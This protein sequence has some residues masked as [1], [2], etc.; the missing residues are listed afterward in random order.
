MSGKA[1]SI[2]LEGA[3]CSG[4]T[5]DVRVPTARIYDGFFSVSLVNSSTRLLTSPEF[6]VSTKL[7]RHNTKL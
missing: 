6:Q 1:R 2:T 3:F 4:A 5:R 7:T